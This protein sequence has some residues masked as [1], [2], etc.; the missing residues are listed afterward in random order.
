MSFAR[1]IAALS[2]LL[3]GVG[4]NGTQEPTYQGWMEAEL[5]FVGP[6]EAGRIET[7]SVR[8][9]DQVEQG[10]LLFVIDSDLQRADVA[11]QEAALQN[12]Q[13]AFDRAQALLK[14]HS[15]TQRAFDDAEAVLRTAQAR[16][17]SAQTRLARRKVA[18]PVSGSVQQV[19]YRT[20]ELVPAGKPIV[21]LLP[22]SNLKVRFFV[23]E[24]VLP[25]L[26]IGETVTITCDGC[27][28]GLAARISFIAR[29]AEFTPPVIYSTEERS[30]LVFLIE[31]RPERPERLRVG[32]PVSVLLGPGPQVTQGK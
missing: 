1:V 28:D 23:P 7:L 14:T 11:M 32:Q 5:I 25:K 19:Y 15:G 10:A 4:C 2:A 21:A 13:I 9:G 16:L 17:N 3:L 29:T 18:S 31:A 6:D 8:E 24:A 22:P 26:Q 12:A 30:K 20:G 27:T